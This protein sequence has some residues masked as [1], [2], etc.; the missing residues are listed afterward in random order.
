MCLR[1]NAG[2]CNGEHPV[3]GGAEIVEERLEDAAKA[4]GPSSRNTRE[5]VSWLGKP[6]RRPRNSLSSVSRSSAN[7]AKSTQLADRGDERDRKDVEQIVALGIASPRVGD[8]SKGVDQGHVS[9]FRHTSQNPDHPE[10]KALFFKCDSPGRRGRAT[11]LRPQSMPTIT[12]EALI[13]A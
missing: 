1:I 11:R 6:F 7:S 13:T 2:R 4:A 5:K 10:R 8:L 9:F 12:S 3:P